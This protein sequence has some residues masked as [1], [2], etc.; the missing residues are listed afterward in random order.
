MRQART[1]R[2]RLGWML[3]VAQAVVAVRTAQPSE[4][5]ERERARVSRARARA[6]EADRW[7]TDQASLL[8]LPV[9]IASEL[10]PT[11]R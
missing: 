10:K 2:E 11:D 8:L 9:W 7:T 1:G 6:T 3:A 4:S 5:R